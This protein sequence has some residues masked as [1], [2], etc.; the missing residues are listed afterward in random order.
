VPVYWTP[1]V[2]GGKSSTQCIA[3]PRNEKERVKTLEGLRIL[4]TPPE[5]R[6]ER[7]IRLTARIFE[8]PICYISLVDSRRQWFKARHGIDL[9]ETPRAISFCSH[10]ILH[11]EPLIVPDLAA[12]FRFADSP[13][14][15]DEPRA[16]FY[17]G[18]PL[19][20]GDAN[21]GTLCILDT[22]PRA[23]SDRQ[24]L[25]LRDLAEIAEYELQRP[26]MPAAS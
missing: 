14:V 1:S 19:S 11:N 18:V 20:V 2:K 6:F 26:P 13:L 25:I 16:R 15:T 4:D 24:V 21:I 17:A 8:V 12:D 5:D 22:K 9:T 23:L 3:I 10:A 7:I